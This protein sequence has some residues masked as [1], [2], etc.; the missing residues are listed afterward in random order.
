MMEE[1]RERSL[2]AT[3]TATA[4]PG[5]TNPNVRLFGCMLEGSK[6]EYK[7]K[8]QDDSTA[9]QLVLRTVCVGPETKDE[10]HVI[11]LEAMSA[12]G[13]MIKMPLTSLKPSV[14]T[15]M[16]LGGFEVSPPVRFRLKTGSGPIYISG[17]HII[18][19]PDSDSESE[20]DQV[21]GTARREPM[22]RKSSSTAEQPAKKIAKLEKSPKAK[23]KSDEGDDADDEEDDDEDEDEEEEEE[24]EEDTDDE[25]VAEDEDDDE[26]EMA[27]TP[28]KKTVNTPGKNTK[29]RED[30][31]KPVK[32]SKTEITVDD[33]KT[34]MKTIVQKGQHL[35][36]TMQK[37]Q[38]FVKS[39]FRFEDQKVV[40][41]LWTWGQTLKRAK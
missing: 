40:E 22:K 18:G 41:E 28:P 33:I 37:F 19:V 1:R 17:E 13:K 10:L 15:S 24:E 7:F 38:N 2:T 14:L 31:L 27:K 6:K 25:D 34:K 21:K 29:K 8:V 9:H 3:A 5:P 4:T 32:T 20:D 39:S 12:N 23:G 26:E 16:G 11:E 36:K 35:P 30:K